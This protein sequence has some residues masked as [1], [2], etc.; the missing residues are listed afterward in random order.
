MFIIVIIVIVIIIIVVVV[1]NIIIFISMKKL[2]GDLIK[3]QNH[4]VVE[5]CN[6]LFFASF[7][8]GPHSSCRHLRRR[9]RCQNQWLINWP[10][11]TLTD[12]RLSF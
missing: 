8:D 2:C 3:L 4:D 11:S 5:F 7:K 6:V 1:I 10:S 9:Q 12:I